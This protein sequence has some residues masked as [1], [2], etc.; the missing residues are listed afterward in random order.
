MPLQIPVILSPIEG[1]T[2]RRGLFWVW[3][4]RHQDRDVTVRVLGTPS[5]PEV[6]EM[7]G[8]S[9]QNPY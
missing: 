5:P 8:V 3:K 2:I 7:K 1:P 4:M 6:R 9:L